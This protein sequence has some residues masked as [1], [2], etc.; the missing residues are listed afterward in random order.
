MMTIL[1]WIG[2]YYLIGLT[3][4]VIYWLWIK[5]GA[6][7]HSGAWDEFLW[8]T[9]A[10]FPILFGLAGLT[11][12]ILLDRAGNRIRRLWRNRARRVVWRV[13]G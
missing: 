2:G 3:L 13:K 4:A 1:A 12:L 9:I 11:V 8:W 6:F 7:F 10:W 5:R